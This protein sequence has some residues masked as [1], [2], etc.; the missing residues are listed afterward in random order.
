M[1]TPHFQHGSQADGETQGSPLS[2]E[3]RALTTGASILQVGMSIG[4]GHKIG[5]LTRDDRNFAH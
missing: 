5:I 3:N 1:D 4:P 2:L